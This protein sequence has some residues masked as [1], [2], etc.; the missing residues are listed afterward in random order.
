MYTTCRI[1]LLG[2]LISIGM[3]TIQSYAEDSARARKLINSQGCKACHTLEGDGGTLSKN[4]ETMRNEMSQAQV[5]ATLVN[6]QHQHGNAKISDFSH[7][8]KKMRK[9]I[10]EMYTSVISVI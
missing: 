4:F 3:L 7:F 2:S 9:T 5:R 10:V 6:E 8:V 1:L